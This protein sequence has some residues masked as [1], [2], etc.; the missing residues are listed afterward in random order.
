MTERV[1]VLIPA[2]NASKS[3]G[4][5]I[6]ATREIVRVVVVV[7]DGSRDDTA[8]VAR[9][10]GAEVIDHPQNRGKGG[11]LKT[12]FAHAIKNGY[13]VVVTLDA[14]GQHLPREIPKFLKSREETKADLI[15]GGRSHLFGEMLPRRRR[16]NRFSAWSIAK[17]AAASPASPPYRPSSVACAAAC[18]DDSR[19]PKQKSPRRRRP[20]SS[21]RAA[22]ARTRRSSCD[23]C[24]VR[25][26]PDPG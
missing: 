26:R 17:A 12:G 19:L 3:V 21:H 16:A 4:D 5:V 10:A 15:I 1:M 24:A 14:D 22:G 18:R 25:I 8:S 20:A 7:N 6:R 23:G 9:A 2:F 11:A 13:D